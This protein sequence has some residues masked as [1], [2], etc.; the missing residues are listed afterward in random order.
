MVLASLLKSGDARIRRLADGTVVLV[1]SSGYSA[2]AD[3][4]IDLASL[5]GKNRERDADRLREAFNDLTNSA[6]SI[7]DFVKA[8]ALAQDDPDA[9]R[10][11]LRGKKHHG[12]AIP[13]K[14]HGRRGRTASSAKQQRYG[15]RGRG[16]PR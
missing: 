7:G 13:P 16:G 8:A 1:I 11:S 9:P 15:R 10:R 5:L 14:Q 12:F 6:P 2:N 4:T 3:P